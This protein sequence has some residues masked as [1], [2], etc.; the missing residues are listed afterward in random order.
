MSS[1]DRASRSEPSATARGS[2]SATVRITWS[3]S[4]SANGFGLRDSSDSSEWVMAS[5]PVAAVAAGGRP[6]VSA[7]SRI[8]QVGSTDGCPTYPLRPA[9]SSVMTP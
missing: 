6:T 4:A 1:C 5:T 3:A 2:Q 8:V 9:A 7:G